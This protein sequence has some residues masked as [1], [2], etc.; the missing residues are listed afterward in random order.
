[1]GYKLDVL[2]TRVAIDKG[3]AMIPQHSTP[4]I[5]ILLVMQGVRTAGD[6]SAVSLNRSP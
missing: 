4:L 2:V 1:M 6:G 3:A 5:R